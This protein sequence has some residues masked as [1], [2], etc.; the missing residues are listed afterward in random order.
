MGIEFEGLRLSGCCSNYCLSLLCMRNYI[1]L[2]A[3]RRLNQ[4]SNPVLLVIWNWTRCTFG[5][6]TTTP[7]LF[8]FEIGL[9]S[10]SW[11]QRSHCRRRQ[12][13]N[14]GNRITKGKLSCHFF[15]FFWLMLL[16]I[17]RPLMEELFYN[18]LVLE[19]LSHKLPIICTKCTVSWVLGPNIYCFFLWFIPFFFI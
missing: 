12:S 19:T 6:A 15:F 9:I 10:K 18:L 8:L 11:N 1:W 7:N 4:F 16:S 5:V 17:C 13:N 2:W 3:I 14:L